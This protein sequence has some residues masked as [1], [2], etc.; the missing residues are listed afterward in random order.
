M[1]GRV[2]GG[3]CLVNYAYK[4]RHFL[5]GSILSLLIRR[6]VHCLVKVLE[7]RFLP[8]AKDFPNPKHS[9]AGAMQILLQLSA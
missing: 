5:L 6:P 1:P 8:V 9:G 4:T 3:V 7:R 2:E